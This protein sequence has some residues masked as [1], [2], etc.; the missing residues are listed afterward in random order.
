[1][2]EKINIT[3]IIGPLVALLRSRKFL[4]ALVTLILDVV[5]AYLPDLE[6][7]RTE[8]L[9]IFTLIGSLLVAAIAYE[10]AQ[11]KANGNGSA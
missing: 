5:I 4:V 11:M 1:M 3:P 7:V 6:A 9:S 8:L 10:D 2:S